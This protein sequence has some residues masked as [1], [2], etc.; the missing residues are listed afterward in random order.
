MVVLMELAAESKE[1]SL[2][3]E[4]HQFLRR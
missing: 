3:R 2:H 1:L 4:R